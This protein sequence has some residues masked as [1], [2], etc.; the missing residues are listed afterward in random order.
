MT[1]DFK[2]DERWEA[3][4]DWMRNLVREELL[5]LDALELTHDEAMRAVRPFQD[6]V[7]ARGL[8]GT[9]LGPDL[10]G[11]GLGQVKLAM[12]HEILGE[13]ELAPLAFGNQPPDSGNVE[14][15]AMAGTDEQKQ[16]WMKPVYDGEVVSSFCM[17]EQGTGSDPTQHVT[18]ARLVGD[19]W[20]VNGRK[21][22]V[23]NARRSMFQI[24]SCVTEPDADKHHRQSLIIVPTDT[25][26]VHTRP[27]G[28]IDFPD[29]NGP[30]H[31]YCEIVYDDVRVP[32][33]NLLG[34]RGEAF[35]LAQKRFGPG[36]VHH[37]M[38][39]MGMARRA[40]NAMI[41]RSVSVS[42]HGSE[43]SQK[44]FIQDFIAKSA[45]ELNA[46]RLLGLHTAWRLDTVGALEARAEIGMLKYHGGEVLRDILDRTIQ[47]HGSL[48]VSTDL[49]FAR[50]YAYA[51]TAR[52]YDG[53]DEVHKQTVARLLTRDVKPREIPSD[54]QPALRK[55][56]LQLF[57]DALAERSTVSVGN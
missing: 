28:T 15:L 42:V 2:I 17:T 54:S 49:P 1:W 43:L 21:W 55:R 45:A 18:A 4:L 9:Y 22:F 48:G 39:W 57:P 26:G 5:P 8:W 30:L 35:I 7:K 50:M 19:R 51:R 38:R 31:E 36:R 56:G 41:E 24:V 6:R 20:V 27:I 16:R 29:H 13:S 44:Q 53:P 46:A 11:P 34:S 47:V 12:M 25:P 37:Y 32:A 3:E 14:L 23:A 33:E 40:L 52:I 10:G